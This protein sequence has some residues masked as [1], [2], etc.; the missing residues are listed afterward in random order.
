MAQRLKSWESPRYQGR[1]R[2]GRG[3]SARHRQWQKQMRKL[4]QKLTGGGEVH[5]LNFWLPLLILGNPCPQVLPQ[6]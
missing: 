2:K 4:R 1:N 5:P 6:F 3:G